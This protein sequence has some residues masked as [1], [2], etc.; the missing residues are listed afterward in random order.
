MQKVYSTIKHVFEDCP[1]AKAIWAA[2]NEGWVKKFNT[3]LSFSFRSTLNPGQDKEFSTKVY[4]TIGAITVQQIWLDYCAVTHDNPKMN[5]PELELGDAILSTFFL[6]MKAELGL[7]KKDLE[8]WLNKEHFSPGILEKEEIAEA[9]LLLNER[10][11][12]LDELRMGYLVLH[13]GI[14]GPLMADI[15]TWVN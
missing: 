11:S 14:F 15:L 1:R 2:V 10:I 5:I 4:D 13:L 9:L 3:P 8:W 7:L 12:T 6:T